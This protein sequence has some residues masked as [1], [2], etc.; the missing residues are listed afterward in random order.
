M[1]FTVPPSIKQEHD[2]LHADLVTA[3]KAGGRT[4]EAA[5]TVAK[6]LHPHFVKEEQYALPPLGMLVDLTQGVA[7]PE[8]LEVLA[9]TDKLKADLRNML[10]E[11]QAIVGALKALVSTATEEKHA[12]TADFARRL[13]HH[14]MIEEQ[15]MYP[16]ALL[17]GEY[18]RLR[19][20]SGAR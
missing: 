20:G 13:M 19:L 18:V 9:M 12:E 15:V 11:H 6:L 8:M 17:V 2:E 10:E 7:D 1:R 16:A 3:T 5:R 4:G 14:A